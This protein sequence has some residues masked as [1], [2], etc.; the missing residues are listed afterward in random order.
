MNKGLRLISTLL[1]LVLLAS[2]SSKSA[3]KSIEKAETNSNGK[4]GS[5]AKAINVDFTV[6]KSVEGDNSVAE[7][8]EELRVLNREHSIKYYSYQPSH[9]STKGN[10]TYYD[11]LGQKHVMTIEDSV[12]KNNYKWE[13]ETGVYSKYPPKGFEMSYGID[14]SRHNGEIDFNKVKNAGFDF[15]IIR[16][17]YR[18]YGKA[19]N[20]KIDENSEKYLKDAKDA[21]LKIGAYV[22]SQAV[23]EEEAIEEA[24]LAT[25]A[26]KEFKLDLPLFFDPETIKN[27]YARTDNVNGE[28]FT[29]NAVAFCEEVRK[30]GFIP[31]IYSNMVWEDYYFDMSKL[32][33]YDIWY[34]D[35]NALPQTPYNFTFWQFS[36]VG[37]VDGIEK[38]VDLNVWIKSK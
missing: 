37:F 3:T 35:Y 4:T 33:E 27:E 8:K 38:E 16:V 10:F 7:N 12:Q 25:D 34:A 29:K 5:N 13:Y 17:V 28:Q 6:G 21:G 22:F 18:G 32:R 9:E 36:E 15:A 20:L 26:L 2:C 31:G 30:A 19:G 11:V 1:I 24:Q 23:N 14:I